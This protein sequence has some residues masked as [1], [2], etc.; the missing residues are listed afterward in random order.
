MYVPPSGCIFQT[1]RQ[2]GDTASSGKE[3]TE[4]D[5]NKAKEALVKGK[6]AIDKMA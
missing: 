4:D 1:D 3:Y 2:Q 6:E 5:V